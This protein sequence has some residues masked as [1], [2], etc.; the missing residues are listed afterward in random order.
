MND[1]LI[2]QCAREGANGPHGYAH[3]IAERAIRLYH[4]RVVAPLEQLAADNLKLANDAAAV[5]RESEQDR[6]RLKQELAA[7]RANVAPLVAAAD[8]LMAFIDQ[9]EAWLNTTYAYEELSIALALFQ[10]EAK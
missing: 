2:K 10:Q 5:L 8:R 4:A 1:E 9:E 3:E 7:L 6:E